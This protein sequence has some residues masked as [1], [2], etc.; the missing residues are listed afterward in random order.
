MCVQQLCSPLPPPLSSHAQLGKERGLLL[1]PSL[2]PPVSVFCCLR[3][4]RNSGDRETGEGARGGTGVPE[5]VAA[6]AAVLLGVGIGGALQRKGR[7]RGGKGRRRSGMREGGREASSSSSIPLPK[8][9]RVYSPSLPSTFTSPPSSSSTLLKLGNREGGKLQRRSN[10][11]YV[12]SP[13]ALLTALFSSSSSS[14]LYCIFPPFGAIILR[15]AHSS[16]EAEAREGIFGIWHEKALP[17]LS[18]L[19]FFTKLPYYSGGGGK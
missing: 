11:S 1:P 3:L 18:L 10:S 15:R 19:L 14:S 17:L 4:Q 5:V 12:H 13:C 7:E 16:S 6:A 9:G 8:C 2:F